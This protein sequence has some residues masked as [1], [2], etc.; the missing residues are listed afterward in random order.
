M[1]PVDLSQLPAECVRGFLA[2]PPVTQR[3]GWSRDP[4]LAGFTVAEWYVRFRIDN[5]HAACRRATTHGAVG[6]LSGCFAAARYHQGR[7]SQ[8]VGR[9]KS[10]GAKS[11]T[12][13]SA[14]KLP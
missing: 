13:K 12:A 8:A 6:R 3:D 1:P 7:L 5:R 2:T 9:I 14:R 4:D 10:A 11:A